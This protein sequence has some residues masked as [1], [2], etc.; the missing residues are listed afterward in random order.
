MINFKYTLNNFF[1]I[2]IFFVS[3]LLKNSNGFADQKNKL[4][5]LSTSCSIHENKIIC[6]NFNINNTFKVGL[7][8]DPYRVFLDFEK[9]IIFNNKKKYKK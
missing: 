8:N 1:L 6:S 3:L 5:K 2:T 9:K 4:E 7:L